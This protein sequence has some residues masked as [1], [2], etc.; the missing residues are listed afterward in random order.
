[1]EKKI[2]PTAIKALSIDLDGTALLPGAILGGRTKECLKRL[3]AGG[4]QVIIN[5]GRAIESSQRYYEALGVEGSMVFFNGAEIAEVPDIR[6]IDSRLTSLEVID[7]GIDLARSMDI[8]FQIYLPAG[9]GPV[10]ESP[11]EALLIDKMRPEVEMYR[12]LSSITPVVTDLKAAINVPGLKGCIKGMFIIDPSLHDDIRRKMTDRFGSSI[13]IVRSF[14]TFLEI[15]DAG[16][17]KG[18][19]LKTVMRHRGLKPEEVIAFGDEDNDLPMFSVAGFSA[20]PSNA[21]ENVK[22]AADFIYGSCADEGLAV[23]LEDLFG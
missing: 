5:T 4:I 19:G 1:M 14:P 17:S 22:Q 7:Y 16:V 6:V 2:N 8:H 10:K 21:K 11:W 20:A 15:M 18:E 23:F 3:M 9:F 12:K 13:Y